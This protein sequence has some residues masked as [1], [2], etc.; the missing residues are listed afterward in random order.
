MAVL[1][2][3]GY[4]TQYTHKTNMSIAIVCMTNFTALNHLNGLENSINQTRDQNCFFKKPIENSGLNSKE[5]TFIWNKN[6]Q[7]K[8]LS[9]YFYGHIITQVRFI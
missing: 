8:I 2:F 4:L 5:G 3:L 7:S 6:D 9:A 1:A